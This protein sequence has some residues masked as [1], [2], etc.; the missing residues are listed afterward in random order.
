MSHYCIPSFF[1]EQRR[2]IKLNDVPS[3]SKRLSFFPKFIYLQSF[4]QAY[5]YIQT[6]NISLSHIWKDKNK[7]KG[8]KLFYDKIKIKLK[9][10]SS[11]YHPVRAPYFSA[12]T[13]FKD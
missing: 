2:G 10:R 12:H 13:R 1:L 6:E 8:F 11:C 4:R 3:V 7:R 9:L 5:I